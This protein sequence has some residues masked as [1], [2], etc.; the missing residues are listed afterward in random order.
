VLT[1]NSWR[2]EEQWTARPINAA[3]RM[4]RSAFISWTGKCADKRAGA[5]LIIVGMPYQRD[6][7]KDAPVA[8][9]STVEQA[10]RIGTVKRTVRTLTQYKPLLLVRIAKKERLRRLTGVC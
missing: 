2:A 3:V 4:R 9:Y 10:S 6:E 5:Q 1:V 8:L 7:R